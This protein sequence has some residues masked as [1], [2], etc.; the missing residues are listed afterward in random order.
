MKNHGE[1]FNFLSGKQNT[2]TKHVVNSFS[3]N[4]K[5]QNPIL[6]VEY[7]K[8]ELGAHDFASALTISATKLTK[9]CEQLCNTG[10]K[11]ILGITYIECKVKRYVTIVFGGMPYVNTGGMTHNDYCNVMPNLEDERLEEIYN[12]LHRYA[13]DA[14]EQALIFNKGLE[15]AY[16]ELDYINK[17]DGDAFPSFEINFRNGNDREP[18]IEQVF[19]PDYNN[20]K[21][22][23]LD[24]LKL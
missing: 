19:K 4:N 20:I 23:L 21:A 22:A 15:T 14:K 8:V 9:E 13:K 12:K 7:E 17:I 18:V 16:L 10:F 6:E 24:S 5:D 2:V 11:F 3:L 1:V